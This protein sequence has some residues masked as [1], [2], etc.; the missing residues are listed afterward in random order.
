MKRHILVLD[1]TPFA[2][3]SKVATLNILRLLDPQTTR[4]S[5][6][7]N[8]IASWPGAQ[9][10]R[11]PLGEAQSLTKQ[12]QG[13]SY[14]ARHLLIALHILRLRLRHGPIDIAL[15]ASGPGVD[16]ALYLAKPLLG[17]RLV[18]LVHGPVARSRTIA[19]CLQKA[20]QVYYLESSRNALLT[21]LA[22]LDDSPELP[23]SRFSLLQNGLP[24]E[25]WP[26]LCQ[27]EQP[28]IYWA[29]SLLKW[30]G[31][32]ILLKALKQLDT[33]ERPTSHICY[34]RPQGTTLAVSQAPVEIKSVDWHHAPKNLDEIR[35]SS[36]IFVSTSDKEPFGLSIL[37]AMAA[38]HCIV[39]PADGAYWDRT[40]EDGIECIKYR[41]GDSQDLANKL[42]ELSQNM[43]RVKELGAAAFC[44][45]QQY[46]AEKCLKEI[47]QTLQE[48]HTANRAG[49]FNTPHIGIGQ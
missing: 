26:S 35:A 41:P 7:T 29:A 38:A 4:V 12:E 24:N 19:R 36:N 20:D 40:L 44:K 18:Q 42:R 32:E 16:L 1:P 6:L 15:G 25:G 21:A 34:I 9:I 5:V 2:G 13:L 14:F 30:K 43:Q 3:G 27:K 37:E 8:D 28:V 39:I 49:K 22:T 11:Q 23:A 10:T 17:Y 46:R 47:T 48:S 45:A 31:L 33:A